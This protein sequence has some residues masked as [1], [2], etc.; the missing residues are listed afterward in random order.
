[1]ISLEQEVKEYLQ[2]RNI[3]FD[4]GTDRFDALDFCVHSQSRGEF[5]FDAKE[6]RQKLRMTNWPDLGIP[7]ECMFI[8][9]DLAVRKAI[10]KAPRSGIVIRDNVHIHYFFIPVIDLALMPKVRVNRKINRTEPTLKGKWLVDLR[11]A[12]GCVDLAEV[13]K[14]IANY[15]DAFPDIFQNILEC[16]GNYIGETIG[17]GG[18]T[19]RPEHWDK[20]VSSTR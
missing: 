1:M 16:Y 10:M 9:D 17:S 20:D 5:Y 2:K 11:N 4:K 19:R 3:L 6:K 8:L 15:I 18:I 7:E 14:C 13:F 12:K